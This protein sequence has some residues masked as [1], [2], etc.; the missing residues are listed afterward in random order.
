MGSYDV[1]RI[2]IPILLSTGLLVAAAPLIGRVH[3]SEDGP[4]RQGRPGDG[5]VDRRGPTPNPAAPAATG[6]PV[7]V[8]EGFEQVNVFGGGIFANGW[9]RQ[10]SSDRP[11]SYWWPCV[12]VRE[13]GA[14]DAADGPDGSCVLSTY[15]TTQTNGGTIS[16]WIVTPRVE[17]GPGS[18]LSFFARTKPDSSYPDRLQVRAC[19]SGPCSNVGTGPEDVGDFTLLLLDINPAE[20]AGVF[21]EEWTRYTLGFAEGVPTGGNGR[22][23]F[24]HYVHDAG[25]GGTRGNL[26][27]LDRVA[28]TAADGAN[29]ALDLTYTVA[30][31]NP[32]DP[33]ACGTE[34]TINV[35][36]G[37]Q[38]NYC[39]R[40]TNHGSDTLSYHSLRD[41]LTGPLLTEKPVT[42]APGQ[43]HQY[44]RIVTIGES[45]APS[46]TW[47]AQADPKGYTYVATPTPAEF[48]D[49]SDGTPIPNNGAGSS[50]IQ[51]FPPDF[52][53]LLNN[54]RIRQY[55]LLTQG[56]FVSVTTFCGSN[57]IFGRLPSP[58]LIAGPALAPL[59]LNPASIVTG[60]FYQKTIGT[61]PNR[62]FIV[63]WSDV[64]TYHD[65]P[66]TMQVI[67]NETSDTIEYR[68]AG[69]YGDTSQGFATG[70]Q[71]QFLANVFPGNGN[72]GD[73]GQIVWTPARPITHTATRRVSV[74]AAQPKL[75]LDTQEIRVS[76]PSHGSGTAALSIRNDGSGRLDWSLRATPSGSRPAQAATVAPLADPALTRL[77]LP[78]AS[79]TTPVT[80]AA[81]PT[82]G[83]GGP[84]YAVSLSQGPYLWS[85]DPHNVN[86]SARI[87]GYLEADSLLVGATFLDDDFRTLYAFDTFNNQLV[88]LDL[89]QMYARPRVV[90]VADVPVNGITGL[91]QDPTSGVV[92]LSSADGQTSTLWTIDP[93]T[94]VAR[95]IGST[96]DAPG[97]ID[98]AFDAQGNLYGVDIALDALVAID[99]AS[100]A[101]QPIGSLGFDANCAAGLAFDHASDTLYFSSKTSCVPDT[102]TLYTID[103]ATG[104]AQKVS[105]ILGIDGFDTIW[106]ALAI[107]HPA[108]HA[109]MDPANVS[110]LQATPASGSQ[111]AGTNGAA[112]ELRVDASGLADGTYTAHL[113]VYSNDPMQRRRSLP[114]TLTVGDG[115]ERIFADGF[116][117][118]SH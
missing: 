50:P 115:G 37:D 39:Y 70:V 95:R 85:F 96:I 111:L 48:I 112:V 21:P 103:T 65:G 42:L 90:G 114:V 56:L 51:A 57:F 117:G 49:I 31:A 110:W 6:N 7:A 26:V 118:G 45:Q 34:T 12:P 23:A 59:W 99:K 35:T 78:E 73:T 94:A 4:A 77:G 98:I 13:F 55:C 72:L 14:W 46:A 47:T 2:A 107:A 68:Y 22:I 43:T 36:V 93:A 76:T 32:D 87:V 5:T 113:C 79:T 100:G 104:Q 20:A 89:T 81:M 64:Q 61:A 84:G 105:R 88:S 97:L 11:D 106:D 82:L 33:Q 9:I 19:N 71:D 29:D 62:R 27:G 30:A 40:V 15:A 1:K 101:A 53:F 8:N 116:D 52:D 28:V 16:N 60:R 25:D 3:A 66:V 44:N 38:V 80:E 92:Y 69:N 102:A 58:N 41:D 10:N 86:D 109:C 74:N 83:E 18:T 75:A 24:R 54:Q 108:R 67:L 91:K 17:F 63:Q